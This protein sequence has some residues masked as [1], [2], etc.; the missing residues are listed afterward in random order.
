MIETNACL[1]RTL[2]K[3]AVLL[4]ALYFPAGH[5]TEPAAP[6]TLAPPEVP[7]ATQ[8][9]APAATPP[10]HPAA[11]SATPPPAVK[12]NGIDAVLVLDSSGSMKHTDPLNLRLPAAKLFIA[13]LGKT[14]RAGVISFSD[15]GYPLAAL[16]PAHD[17][18]AREK[19]L[20]A[21]DK[22]ESNGLFTNLQDALQKARVMLGEQQDDRP[23]YVILMSDGQM[24]TGNAARDAQLTAQLKDT[25]IPELNKA[26][27]TLYTIAFTQSS[28]VALLKEIAEATHGQFR[29]ALLDKDLHDVFTSLFESAKTPDMLPIEG[30]EFH[31]DDA[32]QEVTVVASKETPKVQIFL[33]TPDGKRLAATDASASNKAMRWYSSP[34][35]DMITLDHPAAGIWKVLFSTGKNKAYIVT[36]LGI[37]TDL[38]DQQFKR[39]ATL[40]VTAWLNRGGETVKQPDILASTQFTIQLLGPGGTVNEFIM[41]DTGQL[42]D[43]VANDGIYTAT[44][45]LITLG[46]QKLHLV[47]RSA[48][49]QRETT[50]DINVSEAPALA[51]AAPEAP[52]AQPAVVKPVVKHAAPP[53]SGA[54][55]KPPMPVEEKSLSM[56]WV[57]SGFVLFNLLVGS[58]VVLFIWWRRRRRASTPPAKDAVED[59]DEEAGV[60]AK[61]KSARKS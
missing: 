55:P 15:R 21:V 41:R 39:G 24:D 5:A 19:L 29:L 22:V 20:Q 4:S 14:D 17:E 54:A 44:V 7:A 32:I 35:F 48:T 47:A 1:V 2:F 13:L 9:V 49:F 26:H 18:A 56:A 3:T 60:K 34:A 10:A 58:G 28:D 43:K 38:K 45:P 50:R 59:A 37:V 6:A 61:S 8:S 33:Q 42:G 40:T 52:V 57:L 51:H 27:I 30:G 12:S 53:K 16:M 23:R 36:D 31:A 25:L 46:Q 11:T